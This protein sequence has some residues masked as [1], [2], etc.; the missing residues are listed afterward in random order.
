MAAESKIISIED[1]A[2]MLAQNFWIKVVSNKNKG[3]ISRMNRL[4]IL[5]SRK[6][7]F[8]RGNSKF[9]LRESWRRFKEKAGDLQSQ[10]KP[11]I[12][13]VNY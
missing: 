1:R 13:A 12:Y 9:L 10:N 6:R 4:S 8:S 2:E 7:G 3:M 11:A 5:E